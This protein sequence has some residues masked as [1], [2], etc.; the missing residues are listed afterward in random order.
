MSEPA[1][2]PA[3][4]SAVAG[5]P[6]EVLLERRER[7][8]VVRR[9]DDATGTEDQPDLHSGPSSG[10]IRTVPHKTFLTSLH[11]HPGHDLG[12][13]PFEDLVEAVAGDRQPV[14]AQ[15]HDRA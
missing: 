12:A 11:R 5:V 4:T 2:V 1:L 6:P 10:A 15:S 8:G 3:M 7:P 14:V 13:D 9:A